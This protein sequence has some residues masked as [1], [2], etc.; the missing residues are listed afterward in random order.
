MNRLVVQ[1]I[2]LGSKNLGIAIGLLILLLANAAL[3]TPAS[4]QVAV[5]RRGVVA[6][7]PFRLL[8]TRAGSHTGDGV[9]AGQG[10]VPVDGVVQVTT[11]GR[12]G[13]ANDASG[14]VL[15]VTAVD[16]SAD[17]YI[18]VWPCGSP[19]PNASTLNFVR[20]QTIAN[21]AIT[22][23][24]LDGR[25][26]IYASA[27]T[28]LVVDTSAYYPAGS[29]FHARAPFRLV[30]T[31]SGSLTADALQQGDGLV[32]PN[33]PLEV[34]VAGRAGV[35]SNVG[36]VMLN[37]TV[38]GSSGPGYLT[39]WPCG[40]AM[41]EASTLNYAKNQTIANAVVTKPG[42]DGKTCVFTSSTTHVIVDITGSLDAIAFSSVGPFRLADTRANV[43]TATTEGKTAGL[44]AADSS[45]A[46]RVAGRAGLP[47]D[48]TT[49]V[50]NVAV[51]DPISSGYATVWPCGQTRPN[52]STLN[53]VSGQTI[54]NMVITAAGLSGPD[55]GSVCIYSSAATNLIVDVAGFDSD[56]I[57][58]IDPPNSTTPTSPTTAVTSPSNSNPTTTSPS[59]NVA[60]TTT[61]AMTPAAGSPSPVVAVAAGANHTVMLRADKTMWTF[62][63]NGHGQ[64]GVAATFVSATRTPR[65]VGELANVTSIAANDAATFA[66]LADGSVWTFGRDS[67][68]SDNP[69][70]HRIDGLSSVTAIST[71]TTH[72]L[73]LKSDGTVWSF[74][75]NDYGQLGRSSSTGLDLQPAPITALSDIVAVS[76]GDRFSAAVSSDGALWTFGRNYE[77][78]L[79][80]ST[81][82]LSET[83]PAIVP[84][85]SAVRAISAGQKF[86]F[87]TD[88]SSGAPIVHS[89]GG[90]S[91]G[92]SGPIKG[93]LTFP[94]PV[95]SLVAGMDHTVALAADGHALTFGSNRYGELGRIPT[96][97]S[98][99]A[100]VN[101]AP[102]ELALTQ[103][104]GAATGASHT[105]VLRADGS[106]WTFGD[107][108]FGQLG[109]ETYE[110][111]GVLSRN[112]EPAMVTST[113]P[114][115]VA[116]VTP[117]TTS[118]TTT[119][120]PGPITVVATAAGF[121][122]SAALKSDGTVWTY[123]NGAAVATRVP[124]MSGVASLAVGYDLVMAKSDGTVWTFS[125]S[126]PT[127]PPVRVPGLS[128]ARAVSAGP[129][130]TVVL[131]NDGT[132]WTFG[133]NYNGQLGRS[134]R[135]LNQG[136]D[137]VGG[138]TN[139]VAVSAGR[140][141]TMALKSDGTVWTFGDNAY[142]QLGRV[143]TET[144]GSDSVN[145]EPGL[146]AGMTGAIA[147]A[148][149]ETHSVVLRSDATV[150]T[151]GGGTDA[152]GRIVPT[153]SWGGTAAAVPGLTGVI[154]IAAGN[155]HTVALRNDNTV[156]TFGINFFG[157]LGR[158]PAAGTGGIPDVVPGLFG[159]T[160]ISAAANNTSALRSDG[161]WTFGLNH[162]GQLGRSAGL[163]QFTPNQDPGRATALD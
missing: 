9:G 102:G 79:G 158:T 154:A 163:G 118:T 11:R 127:V 117:T 77:F 119:T 157:Q 87:A 139:I 68:G 152:L 32:S 27:A 52:A 26:C 40:T 10:P 146:V 15:N 47:N 49:M 95:R 54:A 138:L 143:T 22:V 128:G 132:V 89:F 140:S 36:A 81:V 13:V 45:L 72:V 34:N 29:G 135:A 37:I 38:T 61:I 104:I 141:Y 92:A 130:F 3:V 57:T 31:R 105:A 101:T 137:T 46:V 35:S 82:G 19:V 23:P 73:A 156:W 120:T 149:G 93:E 111:I 91:F 51:V 20:A 133:S 160:A 97:A 99:S 116:N 103:I 16:A 155:M 1:K 76:A 129:D 98:P 8:D 148:A 64:L 121:S 153:G 66:L 18:T 7:P 113:V 86:L 65:L 150:W 112:A 63:D 59:N 21:A 136:L 43:T 90:N 60:T 145:P 48:P 109:R 144:L 58:S 56:S 6:V 55:A 107:N 33:A 142:G 62:G 12:G 162:S 71:K 94:T 2:R 159:V 84:S 126:L 115:G 17:G 85:V 44:M 114:A 78:E 74:G 14:V 131:K 125:P 70:P 30:D 108:S 122:W 83:R 4:A 41:P 42:R 106:V 124:A 24:G 123:G 25:T 75:S 28:D 151:F 100:N 67:A 88:V 53:F 134:N 80:R 161:V 50:L 39:V 147:I 69:I 96:A 110:P 5:H